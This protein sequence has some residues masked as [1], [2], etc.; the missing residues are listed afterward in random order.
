MADPTSQDAID[1]FV[2]LPKEERGSLFEKLAPE[3]QRKL[4]DEIKKRKGKNKGGAGGSWEPETSTASKGASA[5]REAVIG[6]FEGL[7]IKPSTSPEEVITGSLKQ[8]GTGVKNLVSSTWEANAPKSKVGQALDT[9]ISHAARTALDIVPTFIDQTATSIE[10]GGRE[11]AEAIRNKDWDKASNLASRTL[12]QIA[13]LRTARKATGEVGVIG[14]IA[15]KVKEPIRRTAQ[16]VMGVD[17]RLTEE[18]VEKSNKEFAEK[19]GSV[20]Q[21]NKEA[22]TKSEE[23]NIAAVE[24]SRAERSKIEGKNKEAQVTYAAETKRVAEENRAAE[25]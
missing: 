13:M 8:F 4:L 1:R 11:T 12:M 22:R 3:K 21:K 10:Q 9:P 6:G 17:S 19:K 7:G 23:E 14:K 24:K 15:E 5:G 20:E 18:A 2:A 25:E 16:G